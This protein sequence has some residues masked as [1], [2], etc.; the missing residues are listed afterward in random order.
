MATPEELAARYAEKMRAKADADARRIQ[1]ENEQKAERQKLEAEIG[2]AF[3]KTLG[4]L[5]PY[6]AAFPPNVFQVDEGFADAMNSR[7]ASVSFGLRDGAAISL[8]RRAGAIH[9]GWARRP[10]RSG[11]VHSFGP[12]LN[13]SE[14]NEQKI[15]ELVEVIVNAS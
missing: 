2:A 14:L 12:D 13:P 15:S 7:Y 1:T 4:L 11:P 3:K 9:V 10:G 6:K 8:E 5:Q